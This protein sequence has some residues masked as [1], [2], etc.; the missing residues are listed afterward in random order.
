MAVKYPSS[1]SRFVGEVL[2]STVLVTGGAG[3]IGAEVVNRLI[4]YGLDVVVIDNLSTGDARRLSSKAHLFE[5]DISDGKVLSEIFG[6]FQITTVFHFAAFKQA[7]ESNHFPDKYWRNNVLEL[8]G[9][10]EE[11]KKYPVK[12]FIL[13]SSCSVY[14]QGGHVTSDSP[15]DP[16]S[17]YG[18]T[19]AVSEKIVGQYS[20]Q[21]SWSFI[22]LRY[23]NVIGASSGAYAG[24]Y[25]SQ[26]LLPSL[27]RTVTRGEV[28]TINGDDFVTADGTAVRDYID[29]RDL[30]NAH[31][32]AMNM[33]MDGFSGPINVSTGGPTSVQSILST[34]TELVGVK[35]ST[36]V[37]ARQLA[38]PGEIWGSPS[39]ELTSAGWAATHSL[40]ESILSQWQSFSLYHEQSE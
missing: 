15:L 12:S 11:I 7:R 32:T 35:V 28:F 31:I 39:S 34:F 18:V 13:S 16:I 25:Y 1:E 8:I 17:T 38:D 10:L 19:K 23:F 37:G 6:R 27:F 2:L 24:D 33:A 5:C 3:Y 14:G 26:C 20:K 29:V 21:F 30:A 22:A 40:S 4:S 9:F 36:V